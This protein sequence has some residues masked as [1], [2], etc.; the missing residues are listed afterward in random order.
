MNR[1]NFCKARL[2]R[3]ILSRANLFSANLS[4]AQRMGAKLHIAEDFTENQIKVVIIDREIKLSS[5]PIDDPEWYKAQ[6]IRS[7]SCLEEKVEAS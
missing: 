5:Y 1:N 4:M 7:H 6:L 2:L 3:A